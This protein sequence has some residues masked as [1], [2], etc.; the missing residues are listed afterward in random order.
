MLLNPAKNTSFFS[1]TRPWRNFLIKLIAS[2]V[3]RALSDLISRASRPAAICVLRPWKSSACSSGAWV[4]NAYGSR[5]A[6]TVFN[7]RA[8]GISWRVDD[9]L[10]TKI[11]DFRWLESRPENRF[12]GQIYTVKSMGAGQ[13]LSCFGPSEVTKWHPSPGNKNRTKWGRPSGDRVIVDR[14]SRGLEFVDHAALQ[15]V[16]GAWCAGS[17][18]VIALQIA[19]CEIAQFGT[20]S[21]LA[22]RKKLRCE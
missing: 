1:S 18:G 11:S 19:N 4:A 6:R 17:R 5:D 20:F 15:D 10:Y 22:L 2:C 3:D 9:A 21:Q 14:I 7:T 13:Q 8:T 16:L 12:S